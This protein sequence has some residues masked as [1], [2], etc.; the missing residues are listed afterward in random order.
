MRVLLTGGAGYMGSVTA[1]RLLHA[2]HEVRVLDSLRYGGQ[3]MLGLF[4]HRG[5]QFIGGD[6]RDA[7][8]V[9]DA[10]K[11]VDAVVHLAA[12]VGDPACAREP[13]LA[14][15]VNY[16]A[17][18]QLAELSQRQGVDRF[19]FASTCSNYGNV[20]SNEYVDEDAPLNP[21]SLYAQ[22]KVQV[23]KFLLDINGTGRV[24]ATVLRFATLFGLSPRMRFDLTVNEFAMELSL[25]GKLVVFGEQFWRPYVHVSDAAQAIALAVEAPQQKTAGRVFNVGDRGQNYQK[26]TIVDLAAERMGDQVEIERVSRSEDPRDYRVAF[27]RIRD[28]LGFEITRTVPDGID[29][30]LQALRQR[31]FE[32]PSNPRYRN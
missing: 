14:Q 1:Q 18:V 19:V 4:A 16:E 30:I 25:H 3:S 22:T 7:G 31:V 17:S 2:G 6:I 11:G 32:D 13:V 24:N 27:D 26:G 29:E 8:C 28:E 20:P 21:V 15:E 12:I 10:L 5:F 23:E 9:A